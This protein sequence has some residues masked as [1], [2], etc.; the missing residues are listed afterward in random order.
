MGQAIGESIT[1]AVG[2]AI[3][4]IP[5][6][7][8]ILMLLSRKAGA[9]SLAFATGWVV[10]VCGAL[11]VVLVVS[12]SIGTGSPQ[13]ASSG[14]STVRLVLG[15]LVLLLGVRRWRQRPAPGEPVTMPRWLQAVESMTPVKS[16]A[17]GVGLSALNPKNLILMI[18]GG[19]AIAQVST[20]STQMAVAAAVFAAL[21]ASSVLLPVVLFH[22]LGQRAVRTL[23]SLSTWLQANNAAVMSVL[24]LLIGVLLIGK[25]VGG[26]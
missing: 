1:F 16:L 21:A 7:A 22:L 26:F 15:V 17:L 25:G 4:P 18:G 6:I 24:L 8:V 10:G 5:V 20:S 23:E 2:V 19:L 3:S 9:N 12:G 13:S 14:T 11:A